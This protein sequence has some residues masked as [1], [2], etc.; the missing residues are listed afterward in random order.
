MW[1]ASALVPTV[2]EYRAGTYA[3]H[4]RTTVAAGVASLDDVALTVLTTVVS[5]PS[6]D[7]AIVDGGLKAFATDRPFGP[8]PVER[9]GVTYEFAGDE[10]GRLW[11][12]D[13][14]R[15]PR[16]GDRVEFFPPHCDPTMNLYDQVYALR[17]Q[18]VEGIWPISA[19][20]K[21]Q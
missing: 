9:P 2:T 5:V 20:G 13:P 10:H 12:R 15:A 18:T 7:L 21:S 1:T 11:I 6:P 16:L 17:G 14:A 4:D 8:E 3:Y 19:R